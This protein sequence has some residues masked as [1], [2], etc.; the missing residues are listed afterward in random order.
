MIRFLVRRE[1]MRKYRICRYVN[2]GVNRSCSY[3]VNRVRGNADTIIGSYRFSKSAK[4][5][6]TTFNEE[7]EA[8]RVMNA[9]RR[10]DHWKDSAYYEVI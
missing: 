1:S 2:D 7:Q 4:K 9:L 10:R 6:A 8:K 3:V 5:V